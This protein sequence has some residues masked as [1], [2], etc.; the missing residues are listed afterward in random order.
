MRRR[1]TCIAMLVL[2][3]LV[4]SLSDSRDAAPPVREGGRWILA[5]DFHVHAFF[6][7]AGLAPW[8]L[9]AEARRR[10]LD[11]IAV[12]N[13]AGVFGGRF[14]RWWSETM[15]GPLVL[16]GQEITTKGYH[17]IGAGLERRV[18]PT[19]DLAET[20]RAVHAQGGVA[21]AAHPGVQYQRSYT[22]EAMR[23]LDGVEAIHA[24]MAEPSKERDELIAFSR[25]AREHNPDVAFIG[26]SDFH[27]LREL[28]AVRTYVVARE[29]SR[30]GVL[31][32]IRAGQT[33]AADVE[34]NLYGDAPLVEHVKRHMAVDQPD[35]TAGA[36]DVARRVA[37][38]LVWFGL[39]GLVLVDG[40]SAGGGATARQ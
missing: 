28:G 14:N 33:V 19:A 27:F 2:G 11:V 5:G 30:R 29:Y 39:L 36:R 13:H 37:V 26:S 21:I 38:A 31:E 10:R 1:V 9:L 34:G 40:V 8:D 15:G 22:P 12:T 24:Q 23:L 25:L 35:G 6:G 16:A 18:E 17:L 3:L 32:A 7:D 20:I 4:G